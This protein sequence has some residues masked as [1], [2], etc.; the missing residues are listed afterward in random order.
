[1]TNLH[2]DWLAPWYERL[3]SPPDPAPLIERLALPTDGIL[4]EVGGGTGRVAALLKGLAQTVIVSDIS[5]PMLRHARQG[6]GLGAAQA[7]VLALPHRDGSIDRILVVDAFHHFPQQER[8][9]HEL[10][11]VL[12]PE[13]RLVI[14]EPDIHDRRVKAIALAERLALMQS[15][16]VAAAEIAQ[17]ATRFGGRATVVQEDAFTVSVVVV[18]KSEG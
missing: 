10:L 1:M 17:L 5:L 14:Q 9:L 6:H 16:F 7:S 2:F 3:I 4:L 13:G 8:A 11:R 15:R 18:E 12:H